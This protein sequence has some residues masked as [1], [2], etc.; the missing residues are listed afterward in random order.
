MEVIF[1][2]KKFLVGVFSALILIGILFSGCGTLPCCSW[3]VG[4]WDVIWWG[5]FLSPDQAPA[6][7]TM[8]QLN[9][10]SVDGS[11]FEGS[12]FFEGSVYQ[13]SNGT[14]L[15]QDQIRFAVEN[16]GEVLTFNGTY[17]GLFFNGQW[18]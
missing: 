9:V 18:E 8:G 15:G 3:L 16:E 6:Q 10:V 1:V 5:A 11:S 13:V 12:Y 17:N 7:Q 2:R 14:V 4:V